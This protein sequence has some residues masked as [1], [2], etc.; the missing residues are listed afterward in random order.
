M[1]LSDFATFSTAISGLAVTASL[2]YL[3]MQTHQAAKHTKALIAQGRVS[4][5][6]DAAIRSSDPE[7]LA[8]QISCAGG[9]PTADRIKMYQFLISC[10]MHMQNAEEVFFQHETGLLSDDQFES[11]RAYL[12]AFF[13]S[14]GVHWYWNMWK[15]QRPHTQGKFKAWIDELAKEI[16][17]GS[18]DARFDG[19]IA[20]IAAVTKSNAS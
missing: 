10:V 3:A 5:N 13:S 12:V 17:K 1:T 8:A 7:M 16:P 2:V 14:R 9:T 20:Q 18:F 4:S 15:S 11:H 19:Y 6:L